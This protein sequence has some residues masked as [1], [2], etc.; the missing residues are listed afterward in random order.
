MI[1]TLWKRL[2]SNEDQEEI[3]TD[4]HKEYLFS[5]RLK[6]LEIGVLTLE[7]GIWTF[8]YTDE[9]RQQSQIRPLINFP[10]LDKVYQSDTL[11]PFFLHRIPG[12]GQP[13]V[14]EI[15][16]KE[17]LDPKDA[18]LLLQ[19]FGEYSIANPFRLVVPGSK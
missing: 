8:R 7:K 11:W 14:Q 4:P 19:R 5:L 10:N 16:K 12:Q 15:I 2:F 3:V 9:F 13:R 1:K 18:G 17:N 6:K